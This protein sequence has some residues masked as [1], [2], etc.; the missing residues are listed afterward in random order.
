[1]RN[2]CSCIISAQKFLKIGVDYLHFCAGG[3]LLGGPNVFGHW[4]LSRLAECHKTLPYTEAW[5]YKR[6]LHFGSGACSTDNF[7]WPSRSL[8]IWRISPLA[9]LKLINIPNNTPIGFYQNPI[10]SLLQID[11]LEAEGRVIKFRRKIEEAI[12]PETECEAIFSTNT[13]PLC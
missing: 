8:R 3:S 13:W 6:K 2:L 1:M 4:L 10:R 7:C 11:V 9:R 12:P 5:L